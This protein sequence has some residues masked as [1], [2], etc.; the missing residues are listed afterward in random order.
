MLK[1]I[2]LNKSIKI[3]P[4]ASI[5]ATVKI[6]DKKNAEKTGH[7]T[8]RVWMNLSE[9]MANVYCARFVLKRFAWLV[10]DIPSFEREEDAASLGKML[11]HV[12]EYFKVNQHYIFY[13]QFELQLS[14]ML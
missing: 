7:S 3:Q 8:Y 4:I 5:S 12:K 1:T 9:S 6:F 10:V 14:H 13:S 2:G 11:S